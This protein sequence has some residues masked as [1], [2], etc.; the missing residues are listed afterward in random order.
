VA[1]PEILLARSYAATDGNAA[2]SRPPDFK[3]KYEIVPVGFPCP[4]RAPVPPSPTAQP[5]KY[6]GKP[7][8]LFVCGA[9]IQTNEF[10]VTG[11]F[12]DISVAFNNG[13]LS[14][15]NLRKQLKTPKEAAPTKKDIDAHI[16]KE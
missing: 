12:G 1:D 2:T 10:L 6:K 11:D 3:A 14:T 13:I 8:P 16:A 4:G 7:I 15:Q 5:G 9:A